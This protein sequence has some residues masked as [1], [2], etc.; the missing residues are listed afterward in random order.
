MD[1]RGW[2]VPG[3]E[4]TRDYDTIAHLSS[5]GQWAFLGLGIY[6]EAPFP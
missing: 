2:K 5:P 3:V 1:F 6:S 4:A